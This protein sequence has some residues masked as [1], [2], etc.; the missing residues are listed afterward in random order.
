MCDPPHCGCAVPVDPKTVQ[1]GMRLPAGSNRVSVSHVITR[2]DGS[3]D[4]IEDAAVRY[5]SRVK[6]VWW[7]LFRAP[8][9]ERSIIAANHRAKA[10]RG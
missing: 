8:A 2:A 7:K 9:V 6:N 1:Q 5:R 4:V 10:L 3:V